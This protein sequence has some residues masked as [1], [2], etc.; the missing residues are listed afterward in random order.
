[1]GVPSLKTSSLPYVFLWMLPISCLSL[2]LQIFMGY[3]F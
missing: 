3:L 2:L 1:M